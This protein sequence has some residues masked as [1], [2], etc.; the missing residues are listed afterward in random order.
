MNILNCTLLHQSIITLGFAKMPMAGL[1]LQGI[2]SIPARHPFTTP[3][4]REI[5]VDKCLV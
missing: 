4:L 5:I 3:G 2:N 1:A